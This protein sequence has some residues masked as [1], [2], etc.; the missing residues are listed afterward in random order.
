MLTEA[1]A[2]PSDDALSLEEKQALS[3]FV[4]KIIE[5]VGRVSTLFESR[6]VDASSPRAAQAYLTATLAL[7]RFAN[8]E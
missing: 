4:G 2:S 1:D 5:D 7:L 3:R 8:H 6:G